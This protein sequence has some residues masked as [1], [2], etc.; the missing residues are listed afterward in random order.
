MNFLVIG[1]LCYDEIHYPDRE[2]V[3]GFGGIYYAIATLGALCG[4]AHKV[5]PIFGVGTDREKELFEAFRRFPAIQTDGIYQLTGPTNTVKLF[6]GDGAERIECSEHIAPP[7]PVDAVQ[8]YIKRADAILINMIS[9]FDI[10]FDLLYTINERK[11]SRN[12]PVYFDIHSMTLGVD[13]NNKRF[14]RPMLDWR[15][16]A[17]N[18]NI[19][20]M[21]EIE[22]ATMS[23]EKLPEIQL[24]KTLLTVGPKAMIVTR[25]K[26]GVRVYTDDKKKTIQTDI[27]A[28]STDG[29]AVP[30]PTGCG[31]VFG[32]A[33]MYAYAGRGDVIEAVQ[34]ANTVAAKK[35]T[36]TGSD[37]LQ[38]LAAVIPTDPV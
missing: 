37:N 5:Y 27:P 28:V 6:Y 21:N 16:W 23:V 12:V 14:R 15:R 22:A 35:A 8:P 30:D 17:F 38:Q 31:D 11:N 25:G 3:Y 29:T 10:T 13:E 2:P 32:A 7:I 18:M 34:F 36:M 4:T 24:A 33:C 26:D 1:H 20:Q 19:V 9:G